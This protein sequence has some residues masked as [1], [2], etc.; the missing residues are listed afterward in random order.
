MLLIPLLV[1]EL[2]YLA[3]ENL[4]CFRDIIDVV[5]PAIVTH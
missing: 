3:K 2:S 1:T 4:V 5:T